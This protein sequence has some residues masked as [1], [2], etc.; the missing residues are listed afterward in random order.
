MYMEVATLA[1]PDRAG[2]DECYYA[3]YA[4][5]TAQLTAYLADPAEAEDVVQEAFLRAWQRWISVSSYDDPVAWVR[6]VAWNVAT[7]RWRR[8]KREALFLYRHP[9]QDEATALLGPDNVALVTALRM[10]RPDLRRV[11]VMHYLADIPVAE[12]ASE[13]GRPKGTI[14]SWLHRGRLQ[15][16][17]LLQDSE[18]E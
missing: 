15:L 18:R 16:S 8:L 1:R 17:D 5:L 12:I 2:F 4:G 3:T 13:L 9:A 10:L 14:V 6:R 7:S 11:I